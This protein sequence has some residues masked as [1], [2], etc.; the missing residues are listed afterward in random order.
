[1]WLWQCQN[2]VSQ[3]KM[4]YFRKNIY[5]R[6]FW[7]NMITAKMSFIIPYAFLSGIT[8]NIP[9]ILSFVRVLQVIC[10]QQYPV[11][12]G[13]KRLHAVFPF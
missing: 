4:Q 8:T 11:A 12:I 2:Q 9:I 10:P 7:N 13:F 1:M 3:R 5:K 6:Q